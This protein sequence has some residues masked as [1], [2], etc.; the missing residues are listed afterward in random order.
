MFGNPTKPLREFEEACDKAEEELV[1]AY[2]EIELRK[3][4][5]EQALRFPQVRAGD[6]AGVFRVAEEIEKYV[7]NA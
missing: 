3:W 5:V 4:S 2:A 1:E 6:T 7:L